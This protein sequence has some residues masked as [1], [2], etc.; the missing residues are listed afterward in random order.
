MARTRVERNIS[1]DDVRKKYYVNLEFGCDP[2][3]GK[4]I[5][6][7]RTYTKLTEARAALRKHETER[8]QG[9]TVIPVPITVEQWLNDWLETVI[10]PNRASTTVYAYR[11]I[12]DNHIIPNLGNVPLQKLTP[13]Q[14]QRYYAQQIT[15][16]LSANTVRKHHD[17]LNHAL[18]LAVV[19]DV[20]AVN[21]VTKVTPPKV[22]KKEIHSI[23]PT[24]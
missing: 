12:I 4:Q 22:T 6:K 24:S 19:Q 16:G 7:T 8:D 15:D 18:R 20:L 2:D 14:I 1:Y 17:L 3:T 9:R 21:P 5:K 13:G 10:K 23:P 11:H